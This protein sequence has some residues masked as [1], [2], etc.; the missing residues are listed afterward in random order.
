VGS[1]ASELNQLRLE[2][3][4]PREI[5]AAMARRSLVYVPLGTVEWHGW[6]LPVGLDAFTAH[7]L[8]L[9]A[10]ANTGGLVYPPL[11][12]GTGGGHGAF[13]WTIMA[14]P[15]QL[16]PLLVRTLQ[17]LDECGVQRAVLFTGHF[18]EEQIALVKDVARA[19]SAMGKSLQA[20]GLS[21]SECPPPPFGL[22]HAGL[23]E[24]SM[25]GAI[26]PELIRL[27]QIPSLDEASAR[28]AR[29]TKGGAER[30]QKD[31]PLYGVGGEDPRLYDRAQAVKLL[32]DAVGW[33]TAEV[34][35]FANNAG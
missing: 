20:L 2:L 26:A 1:I 23:F 10:A 21:I 7:G 9:R 15:E 33:L 11:F 17:R 18:P 30:G 28:A 22:D 27:D 3:R 31:H 4:V 14:T 19:R 29:G 32:S 12:Y 16:E 35:R 24:T 5:E 25:L 13:P 34:E 8:C 6:H